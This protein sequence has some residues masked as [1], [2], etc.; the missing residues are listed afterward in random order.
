[1][2]L[3]LDLSN[4]LLIWNET[5]PSSTSLSLLRSPTW[6]FSTP[7]YSEG[8]VVVGCIHNLSDN[9]FAFDKDGNLLWNQ[10][11]GSI[12]KASP[13]I[14]N[15]TVYVINEQNVFYG[16]QK[17]TKVTAVNIDDGSIRW[18]KELGQVLTISS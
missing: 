16:I 1:M 3:A 4:G 15:D 8:K 12:G 14:Y 18:E 11:I 7:A 9:L 5:F 10:S 6:S 13:V 2:I 17:Q